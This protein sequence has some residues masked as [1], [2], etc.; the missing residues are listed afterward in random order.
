V[1]VNQRNKSIFAYHFTM[2]VS[3]KNI[4]AVLCL[5][6]FP[7]VFLYP[8]GTKQ[9]MPNATA[10]GLLCINKWRNDFAFYDGKAEFRLNI[11]IANTSEKIR[12]GFGQVRDNG[13]NPISDLV[14]R[15]KDSNGL[16][17]YGPFPVPSSGKGFINSHTEAVAGPFT[18]GYDYLEIQPLKTGDYFIEFYYPPSYLD[19]TRHYLDF[20]DITVVNATGSAIN[21][22]IWSK[23]WQFGTGDDLFYA[24]M[25]ILSDDSIV[26]Q[27]NCNGFH[28]GSFSFSSN[29]TGCS[30][31]SDLSF[32]RMSTRDFHT[33]PQYKVFLNDPDNTL[34][35]TQK[36][37]SGIILPVTATTNC[38]SGGATFGIKVE[39]AQSIKI[40]ID[41]NP[42]PGADP[43]DVQ[44]IADV[45]ANP[46]AGDGYNYI[47]WDGND[48]YGKPVAN[49][50]SLSYT[51]TNL[52]GLT[53]LPIYDIEDNAKGFIVNQVR[54]A[55][56]QLKIYWDDSNISGGTSNASTGC[57]S[58]GGCHTWTNDFGNNNTINSWWFV[59][60]SETTSVPIV[61][62]R[63]PALLALSGK[64]VHCLGTTGDLDY[65][66]ANDPN[67][68]SYKWS[69]SGTGVTIAASGTK[70]TLSFAANATAGT[71]SVNGR[72]ASCGDGPAT[73]MDITFESLPKVSLAP[74]QDI[75]YTAPGLKLTGGEP[76]GGNYFVEG[77]PADSLF[78]FKEEEGLHRIVYSYTAPTTCSN[79]D[80]TEIL[81]HSGTECLGTV[82]F[83]TAFTPDGDSLNDIFR[84]VVQNISS[85]KMYIFN[86]WGEL[87]YSTEDAAKGWDGTIGGKACPAG[88]YTYTATYGLSLREDN[89]D[90]RRGM[91][92][93]IR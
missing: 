88:T 16:I 12:F 18:G 47:S 33:Y 23:A 38:T 4:I 27:V 89:I 86:R 78:P 77:N 30:T 90:T 57:I 87:V 45:I 72:N 93:L 73:F 49:S 24:K 84:P 19:D 74:F 34:Y 76:Q 91:F 51:V 55:G 5:V 43:E 69:Y 32:N 83:P 64:S 26:T 3:K 92:A 53:H 58:S 15:I 65:F 25:M 35:P 46:P 11:A 59:S 40:L 22:R 75:C 50:T 36:A 79:S 62:K 7:T 17:V 31:T 6:V 54:P 2:R 81:L 1:P 66:V 68:T 61:T 85:F 10:R 80:T 41:I 48:N 82:Y 20:F 44:I 14:Y 8:E 13:Y 71:L 70:A 21:G 37:P 29:M 63:A 28:G 39:K 9:L 56:G 52:S 42:N 60:W 67:S